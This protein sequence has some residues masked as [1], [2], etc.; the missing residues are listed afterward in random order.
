MN[1]LKL[2]ENLEKDLNISNSK[3]ET[4]KFF[5]KDISSVW[6]W[7]IVLI[8]YYK[9]TN[10][11]VEIIL[12]IVPKE[13]ASRVT[14]FKIIDDA[15]KKKYFSKEKDV[16]DKRKLIIYPTKITIEEFEKWC[17]IFKGF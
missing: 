7:F 11:T 2:L 12:G 15:V 16:N 14:I 8:S 4:V 5:R 6:V 1:Y 13:Y 10:V 17:L 9:N 3:Y